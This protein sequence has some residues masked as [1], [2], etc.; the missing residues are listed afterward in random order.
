MTNRF[1][2]EYQVSEV[3]DFAGLSC[4]IS[5]FRADF[6]RLDENSDR[7]LKSNI[8]ASANFNVAADKIA[9]NCTPKVITPTCAINCTSGHDV[10]KGLS[11]PLRDLVSNSSAPA[12]TRAF[13]ADTAHYL[14]TGRQLPGTPEDIAEYLAEMSCSYAVATIAR[15]L[16]SLSKAH[17][18]LGADDPA[19]SA[20]VTS[21]MRGIRRTYGTAQRQAAALARD[22][23]FIILDML[24]GC[25]KDVRDRAL[26]L[27]GF[28]T[29]M[30]RSEL[31]GLNVEDVHTVQKGA[32]VLLRRSKTDQ[33]GK[34][35]KIAV[36]FGRSRHC[37]VTALRRWLE[38]ARISEGAI[39]RSVDK[40]GNIGS[41]RISGEAVNQVI[42][43]RVEAAGYDPSVYS[44]HSL[45]A[46]FAT[47]AA[48]AGVPTF[49][50]R[51]TT[52]HR[53]EASLARYIRDEDL[54]VNAAAAHVL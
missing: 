13:A 2:P 43:F 45:R 35:R 11:T 30:R 26:L 28:A 4:S 48:Q 24:G 40:H 20:L 19:K 21:T 33:D 46:G 32:L 7:S 12:T 29:A 10:F 49:K 5:A 34:G 25:P 52:G 27:F 8:K 31:V 47:A 54:F 44:A 36:P 39:F 3:S 18:I 14:E 16:A 42:K 50:I 41:Q 1:R 51:Q 17:R 22:D 9:I 38:C 6:H 53:S 37:P 15:R 23:L